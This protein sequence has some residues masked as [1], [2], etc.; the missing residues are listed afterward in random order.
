MQTIR[1]LQFI[2]GILFLC[3]AVVAENQSR[4]FT[5]ESWITWFFVCI[6]TAAGIAAITPLIHNLITRA[7]N[8]KIRQIGREGTGRYLKTIPIRTIE[9]IPY[10][11][12]RFTFKNDAGK[13]L[14]VKTDVYTKS[15]TETLAAMKSFPIKYIGSN[16]VIMLDKQALW[17]AY[18]E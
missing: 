14:E 3:A 16:A 11:K 12:I 1:I 8:D 13:T 9:G 18:L 4:K 10:C 5:I 2:Y 6:F 15:E 7:R 17:H